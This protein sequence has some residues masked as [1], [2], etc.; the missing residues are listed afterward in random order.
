MDFDFFRLDV[1]IGKPNAEL[2]LSV[3]SHAVDA[4]C[5]LPAGVAAQLVLLYVEKQDFAVVVDGDDVH[6][7]VTLMAAENVIATR[8]ELRRDNRLANVAVEVLLVS[9]FI[10]CAP[11]SAG[12]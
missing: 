9:Q 7:S 5:V 4:R 10:F 6:W 2:F 8:N 11:A 3:T 1:D 12:W